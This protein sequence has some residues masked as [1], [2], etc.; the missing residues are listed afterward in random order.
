MFLFYISAVSAYTSALKSSIMYRTEFQPKLIASRTISNVKTDEIFTNLLMQDGRIDLIGD[1]ETCYSRRKVLECYGKVSGTPVKHCSEIF[2]GAI[3]DQ[4]STNSILVVGKAGIGKSLFCQKVI[5]DWANNELFQARENTEIPNLKFVYLL[6]FRQ[7]NLLENNCVTLREI[8]NCCSAL[9]DKCNIDDSTFEYIVKHPKEVMIILD[10]YDEYSQQDYIAGNLE[11]QHPNNARRK[12]P[13]AALCSKLIKGKILR[14]AIVMITSRPDESDKMGGIRFKRYVE[15]AGFS[16]EQV[17]EYIEKYFK[18]NENMKNAVLK[19]VMNNENLVSFAHIPML[20]YL[21]CFEMEYTLTESE[22]S[23]DLPVSIT[24]IYTKLVDI[25]ELKHCAESEYRQKEIPEKFKPPPVIKNTLEKLSKLA[26]KLLVE[27]KPTFDE[28]E[29][30]GDFEAEEVNKLK[31]SGL[32]Y[33][34]QPFRT[35]LI[36][37]TKHFSFTHLTVQEFLAARWFV[38]ENR[39]PDPAKC[40]EMVFQFMAGVLSNEKNEKNEELMEKLIDL[41][42]TPHLRLRCLKEYRDKEFVKQFMRKNPQ[43]FF[44]SHGVTVFEC[45]SDVRCVEASFLL[46]IISELNKEEAGEAQHKYTDTFFTVKSLGLVGPHLTLSGIQPVCNSLKNEHCLV[47][48]LRL[49]KIN[50]SDEYVDFI[51]RLLVRRLT[52][53]ILNDI[54]IT[55]SSVARLC[56]ALQD[57]SCK[58]TTLNLES[59]GINDTGVASLGEA[60]QHPSCKLTTL[61]LKDDEITDTGVASLR[62]ALQHPSCKLTTLN[63]GSSGINDIGVASLGEALQHPG[64]QLTTLN[65]GYS[66]IIET[67]VVSLCEALQHPSC[68]LTT[69]NLRSSGINDIG[70]ASLG[71]ALQHPSCKLTTLYLEGND[72]TDIG[73]ASLCEA[74]KHPNSKLTTLCISCRGI[75]DTCVPSL[76]EALQHSSCKLTTLGMQHCRI[77]GSSVTRLFEASQHPSCKLT[78]LELPALVFIETFGIPHPPDLKVSYH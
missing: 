60:L 25:F 73:V 9:D 2:L 24:D 12:M 77:T 36:T 33:C 58:L 17:K 10:G 37:T 40:S 39:V 67:G 4:E 18:K 44:Q 45:F 27:R 30:E 55:D 38:K 52:T 57:P 7:L 5:R 66:G 61:N 71:K 28:S 48:L 6:T 63:L 56:E 34:G 76:C 59:S 32:L 8:L 72:I 42:M 51:N 19:H 68:K 29:M 35:A 41:P 13:V 3:D 50:W 31:G 69:L 14:G 23:D 22:N 15:I 78:A 54:K 11:E 65:L 49:V 47:S 74:L 53:L 46:D 43:A 70:V 62:E 75:G 21:L 64:C 1:D 20:C 26:A 16:T